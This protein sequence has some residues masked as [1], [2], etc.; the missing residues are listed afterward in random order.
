LKS[1]PP[2]IPSSTELQKVASVNTLK[3]ANKEPVKPTT[4]SWAPPGLWP[5]KEPP[6]YGQPREF[7]T[8]G[9]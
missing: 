1:V 6:G 2:K 7:M 9:R 4:P 3:T 8:L 5:T